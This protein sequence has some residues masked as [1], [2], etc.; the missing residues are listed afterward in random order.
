[1][2]SRSGGIVKRHESGKVVTVNNMYR[3]ERKRGGERSRTIGG[4]RSVR[5]VIESLSASVV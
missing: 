1:M 2:S 4:R 3:D 5:Y